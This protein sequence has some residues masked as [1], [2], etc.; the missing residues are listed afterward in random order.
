MKDLDKL[1]NQA[2]EVA[3]EPEI[4]VTTD[5]F[6]TASEETQ[7]EEVFNKAQNTTA[8]TKIVMPAL[9]IKIAPALELG[10]YVGTIS[11]IE[12]RHYVG[13]DGVPTMDGI[14]VYFEIETQKDV[15]TEHKINVAFGNHLRYSQ[16][17][18]KEE[19]ENALRIS[20][21]SLTRFFQNLF[22]NFPTPITQALTLEESR[23]ILE[24]MK[25]NQ[26]PIK[27]Y[28]QVNNNRASG[29]QR[30]LELFKRTDELNVANNYVTPA[31]RR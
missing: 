29:P 20:K 23:L 21:D 18:Q 12:Y 31:R 15:K 14:D 5:P 28:Y 25:E 1:F 22:Q 30:M 11:K 10:D 8:P 16:V 9:D 3:P 2:L 19:Y 17:T 26:L 13:K 7:A 24:K 27:L 6:A 4:V